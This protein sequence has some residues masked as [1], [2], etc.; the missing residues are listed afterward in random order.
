MPLETSAHVFRAS[1]ATAA[2]YALLGLLLAIQSL[3]FPWVASDKIAGVLLVSLPAGAAAY[4]L[5]TRAVLLGKTT[6]VVSIDGLQLH[7]PGWEGGWLRPLRN[8]GLHWR[9]IQRVSRRR[10]RYGIAPL[11]LDVEE[12][13]I[14]SATGTFILTGNICPDVEKVIQ[15][16]C[17]RTG[18]NVSI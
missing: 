3:L 12:Y 6:I 11:R 14:E 8:A 5:L 10:V 18:L 15:A 4:W 1:R 17:Q 9:D 16:V 7:I 13:A 2:T